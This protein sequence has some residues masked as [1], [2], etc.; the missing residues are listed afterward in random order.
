MILLCLFLGMVICYHGWLAWIVWC[1]PI[2]A[3]DAEREF[4]RRPRYDKP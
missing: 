3:D 2:D 4:L 1:H